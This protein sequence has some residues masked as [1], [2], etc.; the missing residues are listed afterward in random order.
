MS[1]HIFKA[2]LQ[3]KIISKTLYYNYIKTLLRFIT[4]YL[5]CINISLSNW[6][7]RDSFNRL[8]KQ[9]LFRFTWSIGLNSFATP[10]SNGHME[11]S[12]KTTDMGPL[13][14]KTLI[15]LIKR[16]LAE[17]IDS[18]VNFFNSFLNIDFL[19]KGF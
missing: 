15:C 5:K 4:Q 17:K 14:G 8:I 2:V 3:V 18:F 12:E 13:I 10:S 16:L 1:I 11:M 19:H 7:L 6:S 9:V